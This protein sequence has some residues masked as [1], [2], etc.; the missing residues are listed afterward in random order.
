MFSAKELY[1]K[2]SSEQP[3]LAKKQMDERRSE[4][5]KWAAREGFRLTK[6]GDGQYVAPFTSIAWRAY[7]EGLKQRLKG[8]RND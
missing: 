5:E 4:F 8:E 6:R 3:A 2:L 1:M 7:L